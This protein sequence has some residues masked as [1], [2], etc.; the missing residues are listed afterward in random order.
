VSEISSWVRLTATEG[1]GSETARKLLSAFGLPEQIFSTSFTALRQVV[2]ERQAN[3]LLAPPSDATLALIER[4]QAWCAEPNNFFIPLG[5]ECYP[6]QLLE[7]PDPPCVLYVKGRIDLLSNTG[8]AVV[9]SRNATTQGLINAEQFSTSLSQAGLTVTS[10]LALGIDTAAH[11]GAL[12][13]AGSTI[14][15]IGTGADIVYPARNRDL[16]HR[17][18]EEG[19]I[20]SEYPLG[21]PAVASNF[22]RRNR[23]ISGLSKGV[24][25]IEAALQSGSLI[26]ARM[27]IEQGRDVF[28]IP[29]SIHSPLAKGCHALIKQGAK[30][31]ETA[32]DILS[33][34][35]GLR[36]VPLLQKTTSVTPTANS[37]LLNQIGYDPIH[38]DLLAER[39][40][41]DSG[42]LSAQLLMLELEG[43]VEVM[44]GGL[45]RRLN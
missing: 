29:G 43:Q 5:D 20:V 32:D 23:L 25:I 17:I 8:I 11:A 34:L 31:V 33:E 15:V 42:E 9:G 1:V 30:L 21:T 35:P 40:N 27:A 10:G 19:C 26:T 12:E 4:T 37:T 44:A 39:C 22:P 7:I 45:Y 38:P 3:A 6:A 14:A 24:L 28:A 13:G 2:S 36:L 41:I 16:A 18:A